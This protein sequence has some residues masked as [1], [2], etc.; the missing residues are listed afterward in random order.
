[1]KIYQPACNEERIEKEN[2]AHGSALFPCAC[3]NS[4]LSENFP[5]FHLHWHPELEINLVTKGQAEVIINFESH[6]VSEGDIV[7]LNKEEVHGFFR[8]QS[9][10]F[11]CRAVLFHLDFIGA[12][13]ADDI[14]LE[15]IGPLSSKEIR[16]Q[17]II[18][19]NALY[20]EELKN[21]LMKI[22]DLYEEKSP[23][24]K[25]QLKS[26]LLHIL[27]LLFCHAQADQEPL[28]SKRNTAMKAAVSYIAQNYNRSLPAAE[29]AQ[30]AGYSKFHFLRI[31]KACT[32]TEYTHYVNQVRFS[33]A[34]VLLR[35]TSLSV[36]DIAMTV[37]FSDSA[38]FTKKFKEEFHTT[39]LK[40]RSK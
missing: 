33:R 23:F 36:T 14:F 3:Y 18:C 1:M 34:L 6:I 24:Y 22:F 40:F 28:F 5:A 38:Y 20:Y 31:F 39:P 15:A 13:N 35:E 19:T 7:L 17:N 25:V 30:A 37:G 27:Y 11:N 4:W 21:V 8:C 12:K 29:V 26:D 16:F 9:S 32:G 2:A 10:D